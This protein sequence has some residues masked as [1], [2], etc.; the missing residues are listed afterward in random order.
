M[1]EIW[2]NGGYQL[3]GGIPV[4]MLD[5]CA[6][7]CCGTILVYL[8]H[9]DLEHV[10]MVAFVLPILLDFKEGVSALHIP[11]NLIA[12]TEADL[13]ADLPFFNL[14]CSSHVRVLQKHVLMCDVRHHQ[15]NN[16]WFLPIHFSYLRPNYF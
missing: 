7:N 12:E 2:T 11:V 6:S 13:I 5:C 1:E 3:L 10:E 14:N 4:L 16:E 15:E 9:A 8:V